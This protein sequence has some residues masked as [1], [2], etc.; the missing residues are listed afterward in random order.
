MAKEAGRWILW[1]IAPSASAACIMGALLA[2]GGCGSHFEGGLANAPSIG[3]R[4]LVRAQPHDVISNGRESCPRG[5][6]GDPFPYRIADCEEER[7]DSGA[8]HTKALAW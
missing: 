5:D 6:A 8:P 7:G 3:R 2:A 1:A 4:N